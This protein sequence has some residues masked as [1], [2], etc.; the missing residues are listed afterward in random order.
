MQSDTRGMVLLLE[1]DSELGNELGSEVCC[2]ELASI[3]RGHRCREARIRNG[4]GVRG[5]LPSNVEQKVLFTVPSR[6]VM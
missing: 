4:K 2:C 6:Q 3:D 5:R 1:E